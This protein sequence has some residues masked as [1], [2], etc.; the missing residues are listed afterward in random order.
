MLGRLIRFKV[1]WARSAF[2]ESIVKALVVII[3]VYK[4]W[5]DDPF[6]VWLYDH[7]F[8][9]TP[10]AVF[11]YIFY[12]LGVGYLDKRFIRRK[13]TDEMTETNPRFME[14]YRK[15][16]DIHKKNVQTR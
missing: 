10:V 14:M 6:G 9:A 11:G 5:E 1:Y 2:Y 4:V 15:I 13:E 16:N 12:R 3:F 8:I 7:R